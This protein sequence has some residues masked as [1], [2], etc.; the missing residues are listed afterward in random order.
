LVRGDP[1]IRR[2]YLD[3]VIAAEQAD[4]LKTLQ[5]YQRILNQRN[6]LLKAGLK[7]SGKLDLPMLHGFTQPLCQL[8]A[9]I[10][11]ERLQWIFKTQEIFQSISQQIVQQPSSLKISY[12]S[13]WTPS[14]EEFSL[15][16]ND[17]EK[18]H[19]SGQAQEASLKLLEQSFWAKI[20]A[21]EAVERR[22]GFCVVGPHRDDWTFLSGNQVLKGHASQGEVRSALLALKLTEIESFKRET[23][24]RP[25]FLMDDFSS[26]LDEQRRS[27]LLQSLIQA[28]LQTLITTTEDSF[29]VGKR[30]WLCNGIVKEGTHDD[31]RKSTPVQ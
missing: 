6:A 16:N 12:L 26:E 24:H 4:Y 19:F 14:I 5:T 3:R 28:D 31:R 18:N 25:L 10:A 8:G 11:F 17:L 7:S 1:S 2:V 9:R 15:N 27:F 30:F 23:G 29:R 20:A 13:Q 21:S 22:M